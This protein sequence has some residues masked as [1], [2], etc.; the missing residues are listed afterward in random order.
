MLRTLLVGALAAAS[1]APRAATFIVIGAPGSQLAALSQ[2]GCVGA[3]GV[4]GG[5]PA[6]F[7]WTERG[8]VQSLR[9][10]IAVHGLSPSGAFVAGSLLDDLQREVAGY[11][12]TA[13]NP[14]RLAPMPDL[15]AVGSVS[16]AHAISDE[17]RVVGNAR[18]SD[19]VRVAFEWSAAIGMRALP[20]GGGEREFRAIAISDDGRR[21][22]GWSRE[23]NRVR[24]LRWR[25]G[26]LWPS[27]NA[28][29]LA[30]GEI[31]GSSHDAEALVGW[32]GSD[33]SGAAAVFDRADIRRLTDA[34][35]LVRL[36]A[37]SDDGKVLVGDSGSGGE[38]RPWVWL[39]QEGFVTLDALLMQHHAPVPAGWRPLSLTAVSANGKRLGGWGTYGSDR[40]DSFIVDLTDE[41]IRC[42]APLP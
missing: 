7:R 36:Q 32:Q 42:D 17:P 24:P 22:A 29:G 25:D 23:G 35:T 13:G 8:G 1:S 12:D 4:L 27:G 11:W 40:L 14:H 9:D 39:Q 10:S 41:G 34:T 38:R 3:G 20:S 26:Q 5:K 33:G 30:D 31:L 18:R 37:S 21:I 16:Q 19:G 6:G 15:E 2:D 28:S